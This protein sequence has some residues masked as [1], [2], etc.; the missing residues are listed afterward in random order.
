VRALLQMP[1]LIGVSQVINAGDS[2][3]FLSGGFYKATIH[4]V[5][6]PPPDQR[7]C[8]RLGVFYFVTPD[9]AVK[10]RPL[11]ESPVL[12]RV[13]VHDRFSGEG[14]VPPTVGMWSKARTSAYGQSELTKGEED[15]TEEE[16]IGGVVVK[17][18][19]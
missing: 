15:G 7:N 2:L 17:H 18:Y 12:Q 14:F 6:Q 10:L 9:D 5:V 3:E 19:N 11:L 1:Q 13:G 16:V 8:T 4:R